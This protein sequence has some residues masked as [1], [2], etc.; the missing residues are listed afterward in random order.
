MFFARRLM[1]VFLVVKGEKITFA[2]QMMIMLASSIAFMVISLAFDTFNTKGDRRMAIYHE[3]TILLVCYCF[4]VFNIASVED[5]FKYGYAAIVI[6]AVY[7]GVALLIMIRDGSYLL[8]W[9]C[10]KRRAL[11]KYRKKRRRMQC[12]LRINHAR[13]KQRMKKLRKPQP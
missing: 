8:K 9:K 5:N 13:T 4:L 3:F 12:L 2:I 6:V 10:R 11:K 1:L 7:C